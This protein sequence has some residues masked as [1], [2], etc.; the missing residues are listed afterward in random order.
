MTSINRI[1]FFTFCATQLIACG[2]FGGSSS[3]SGHNRSP[4]SAGV[5]KFSMVNDG[6][7]ILGKGYRAPLA[8]FEKKIND[9]ELSP[10]LT[11]LQLDIP[12]SQY[13][14][15][16]LNNPQYQFRGTTVNHDMTAIFGMTLSQLTQC[17]AFVPTDI[18]KMPH[19]DKMSISPLLMLLG[20]AEEDV[21]EFLQ[22]D[23]SE[24]EEKLMNLTVTQDEFRSLLDRYYKVYSTLLSEAH[25]ATL[26]KW[27]NEVMS[28]AGGDQV[29]MS[30]IIGNQP[31]HP[32]YASIDDRIRAQH[33]RCELNSNDIEGLEKCSSISTSNPDDYP[34]FQG[35]NDLLALANYLTLVTDLCDHKETSLVAKIISSAGELV[36]TSNLIEKMTS[37]CAL[38]P[39]EQLKKTTIMQLAEKDPCGLI[40]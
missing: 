26:E 28:N 3:G 32:E 40:G 10:L 7:S 20:L 13:S 38:T 9:Q 6:A 5:S 22:H 25:E 8:C 27:K 39:R 18:T 33:S 30:W 23:H 1:V 12:F 34:Y 17:C 16:V 35:R 31:G 29:S 36:R 21:S 24:F 11:G 19:K 14:K 2:L 37:V 15:E 4:M